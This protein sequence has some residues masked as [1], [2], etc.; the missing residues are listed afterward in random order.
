MGLLNWFFERRSNPMEDPSKPMAASALNAVFGWGFGGAST[1]AGEV[2]NE[3]IAMQHVT[4][5]SCVR[6]LAEAV[7]SLT[8]RLYQRTE[9][10]RK[11]ATDEPL[12]KILSLLPNDEM[13]ASVIWENAVGCLALTG[14]SYL[15]ILRNKKGDA[16]QLYPLHP[17]KTEPVRLPNGTLA[18]RTTATPNNEARII[19]A[20]DML[21]FRL[22]SWDG[23]VGLSPIKQARQTIGWST[24]ALKQSA[25]LFGQGSKPPGILTPVAEIDE[26]DLVN[27]RK[28]WELAN[29]GENQNRTAVLPSDWKYQSIG[30]NAVDAQFLESMQFTRADIAS[31]FRIPAH[32][33]GDSTKMSNNNVEGMN[34]S[35]V[36]DTL[37]PYL[38]RIEQEICIKLLNADPARFVEFDTTER[39]RG[40]FKS[41]MDGF[42]VGRQWG[43]FTT[44]YC[45][46]KLG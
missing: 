39:L 41:T 44:N 27:M 37:R 36:I 5:Y 28:A 24:A 11:E 7:G 33:V 13:S 20:E 2:I 40:D 22:F 19:N 43:I 16:L 42:A 4:V 15:E 21:H 3:H 30:M 12:W 46:E 25:R 29:G 14:N 18:Y 10:G 34:L 1:A 38:V 31:L 32:M 17:L 45:L 9:N 6:I 26:T 23:I 8:A 35:F